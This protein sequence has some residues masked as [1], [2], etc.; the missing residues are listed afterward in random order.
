MELVSQQMFPSLRSPIAAVTRAVAG[1]QDP[2]GRRSLPCRVTPS[3][4]PAPPRVTVLSCWSSRS[5]GS[6][7]EPTVVVLRSL[8]SDCCSERFLTLIF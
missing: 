7:R 6:T 2:A 5:S 3:E 8:L 4:E 1:P